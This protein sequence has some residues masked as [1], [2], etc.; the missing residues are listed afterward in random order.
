[1]EAKPEHTI[2]K[3]LVIAHE[4]S[5]S[6]ATAIYNSSPA[7]TK[8]LPDLSFRA[9]Q[10]FDPL[11]VATGVAG[12]NPQQLGDSQE[13]QFK[14]WRGNYRKRVAS[15]R[16]MPHSA[17]A[18]RREH[19]ERRYEPAAGKNRRSSALASFHPCNC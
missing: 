2:I 4:R 8:R 5:G 13:D 9:F 18:R 11:S 16:I 12:E 15:D 1:M 6:Y 10:R 7:A 17:I 19:R 14:C 3:A